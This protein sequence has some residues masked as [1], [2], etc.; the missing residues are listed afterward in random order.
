MLDH[1]ECYRAA[2]SRDARFDGRF[3]L[4]VTSTGIYCRPSCA[5]R[6]PRR[7]NA[8]FYATASAAE[9]A[10]FRPCKRCRPDSF[11]GS[12]SWAG[13]AAIAASAVHLIDDGVVDREGVPGLARRLGYSPRQVQRLLRT[14]LGSGP[15]ALARARRIENTRTLLERT[16]MPISEVAFAAGFASVRQFNET[17]H[18]TF[19]ST[20]GE[21]RRGAARRA[22]ERAAGALSLRLSC[23]LPFEF[24]DLLDELG[25][26]LVPGLEEIVA[27]TY[28]RALRLPHGAGAVAL[29]ASPTPS[30]RG[31]W[32]ATGAIDCRLVLEDLRDLPVAVERCRRLL[33]LD[34]DPQAVD[35]VLGADPVLAPLVA[36]SPG[37]RA[38]GSTDP[39][40]AAVRAL[41]RRSSG[42][43]LGRQLARLVADH[44]VALAEGGVLSGFCFPAPAQLA[45]ADPRSLGLTAGQGDAVRALASAVATGDLVLEPGETSA[46]AELAL[47]PGFGPAAIA[48]VLGTGL[49]DPDV[50]E[51][52]QPQVA[53]GLRRL[54]V[55]QAGLERGLAEGWRPWRSYARAHLVVAGRLPAAAAA[56]RSRAAG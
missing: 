56:P 2:S 33:D 47:L 21:L 18:A 12:A 35:T 51:T 42:P 10:G 22:P 6:T 37:R 11:P 54:R 36:A 17:V 48:E 20:P 13:R 31:A 24:S 19:A 3:F 23:R 50:L 44:G 9:Q 45:G 39:F 41:L 28:R 16:A 7:A 52:T 4:A 38:L 55:D 29:S 25:P 43:G 5:A 34:A 14:E 26:D 53:A 1:E 32:A 15:L 46:A 27:S 40:E 49:G 30:A 8:R